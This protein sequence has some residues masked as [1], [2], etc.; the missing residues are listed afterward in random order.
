MVE[1]RAPV[2]P[3]YGEDD[4]V[5]FTELRKQGY[6]HLLFDGEP[7]ELSDE[8]GLE[9]GGRKLTAIVDRIR[10]QAGREKELKTAVQ[11]ALRLGDPYLEVSLPEAPARVVERFH[12]TWGCPE[13]HLLAGGVA[14][15]FFMFNNPDSA[16][17]TCSG[18]GTYNRV[19][20]DLLVP[21][22][23]RSI[24]A[25]AFIKD[26][27]NPHPD[28]WDGRHAWSLAAHY[29]FSLD[30]PFAELPAKIVDLPSGDPR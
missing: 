5:L 13:H 27:W 30:V 2:W 3:I 15:E 14:H 8:L 20:P 21:D 25:G 23:S 26:A 17:R 29:G 18:L 16:C 4:E 10:L 12:R 28:N 1:L 24:L 9:T 22:P 11:N 6:R 7:V 19:H